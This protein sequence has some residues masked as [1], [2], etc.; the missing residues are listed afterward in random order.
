MS[1]RTLPRE[2]IAFPGV[3][4]AHP[5]QPVDVPPERMS[6]AVLLVRITDLI[7]ET[8]RR[9]RLR[10]A[11]RIN[12]ADAMFETQIECLPD[13]SRARIIDH[14]LQGEDVA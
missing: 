3:R 8:Q 11:L 10:P 12:L 2:V 14:T 13:E 4:Q 1:N 5:K 6:D 7:L 9:G